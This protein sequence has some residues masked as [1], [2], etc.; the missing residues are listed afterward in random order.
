MN[1]S[2]SNRKRKRQIFYII[3]SVIKTLFPWKQRKR[4]M[5]G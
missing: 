3:F 4:E 1:D 2:M 5:E